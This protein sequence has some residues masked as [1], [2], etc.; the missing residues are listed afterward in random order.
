MGHCFILNYNT[1]FDIVQPILN[2]ED[3]KGYNLDGPYG[4]AMRG[5][6]YTY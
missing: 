2:S 1:I 5:R 4:R 3:S 6:Q